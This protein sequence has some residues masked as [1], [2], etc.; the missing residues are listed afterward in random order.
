LIEII[1][2]PGIDA[3]PYL[4]LLAPDGADHLRAGATRLRGT[5]TVH[6]NSTAYGGGVA[7]I[8]HSLI[9][10]S[11][12]LGVETQRLVMTPKDIR[13]FDV[14][15]RIHNMLQGSEGQLSDEELGIYYGCLDAIADE[16]N[17]SE[18]QA[19]I[20]YF[21][22]PQLLPLGTR[23][24]PGKAPNRIWIVHIDLTQPNPW[25]LDELLPLTRAYHAMICSLDSYVPKRLPDGLDVFVAPPA[26]DPLTAKNDALPSGD[27]ARI[28]DALC[29]DAGRPLVTQVS[30]FDLWKDPWGVID[31]Y[32]LARETNP[33][34]QLA[35]LGLSQADDDPEGA[36]VVESVRVHTAGDPDIHLFF[37][38]EGL[39]AT[40]DEVVN[41]LQTHSEVLVQKSTR[42]G[43]GLTV[44]EGMWKAKPVIGG[45]VGG[46]RLQIVDGESGYLVDNAE[47]AGQ[48]MAQLLSNAELR[49]NIG[50]A[51]KQRVQERFLL[52][53]LLDDYWSAG[54]HVHD[55][56]LTDGGQVR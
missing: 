15:K 42:E 31:A 54:I 21:H 18:L 29:I 10:L 26:I 8:L 3:E 51:A 56:S 47:E 38:P 36:Q 52:P 7:E 2:Y 30:R 14:T 48:R 12:A 35:L 20:W 45:N 39:P 5:K 32:R 22:D 1:E 25:L 49:A 37:S 24:D 55:K 9:P 6:I 19:D 40:N 11:N 27:A 41:A 43:F 46:I 28:V 50:R 16:I 53:R 34:L 23:I 17:G 4:A 33:G 44:S 13:F